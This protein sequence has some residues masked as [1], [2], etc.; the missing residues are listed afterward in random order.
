MPEA[1]VYGINPLIPS[2]STNPGA[3]RRCGLL[4]RLVC[5]VAVVAAAPAAT[6]ATALQ[7]GANANESWLHLDPALLEQSRTDWVRGFVP[8]GAFLAAERDL[9]ADPELAVLERAARSGR[10]VILSLKWDFALRHQRVP[11]PES[12]PEARAFA[13]VDQLLARYGAR[14]SILVL[15][16]E[17][18]IDTAA[19]D[20]EPQPDGSVP[21]A[22]FLSR[23]G[24]HVA[25][26][27]V[28]GA[29]G[30]PLPLY[31]GALTRLDQSAQQAA[32]TTLAL[33]ADVEHAPYLQGLDLHLH[34]RTADQFAL[35]LAFAR[36]HVTKP[37]IVTEFS[38]IW[39]YRAALAEPIGAAAAGQHFLTAHDYP[40]AWR[41]LDYVNHAL[42]D[43]V[44][45]AE[46]SE[47]LRSQTWFDPLFLPRTCAVMAAHGVTVATYAFSHGPRRP[48]PPRL[49]TLQ[50]T[51]WL[52]NALFAPRL[53]AAT[54]DNPASANPLLLPAYRAWQSAP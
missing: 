24:Q 47:F 25:A 29:D 53:I 7:L 38:P 11:G 46:W 33:L 12:A 28:H 44:P 51:P 31:L 13:C 10:H 20:L 1:A 45:A 37:I 41:V 52:L 36:S 42:S 34:Q 6:R 30:Q 8:V 48:G 14:L 9:R 21:I 27:Q 18:L 32:P 50:S 3:P 23:L 35:A 15:A 4:A 16:N 2:S 40:S 49:L 54:T 17:P 5:A 26:L 43:P 39:R 19:D 22:T